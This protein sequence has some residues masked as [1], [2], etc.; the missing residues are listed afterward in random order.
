MTE[1][2]CQN[3]RMLFPEEELLIREDTGEPV[4]EDCSELIQGEDLS[5]RYDE[6]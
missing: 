6:G 4:C 5:C 1:K 2:R 3:C